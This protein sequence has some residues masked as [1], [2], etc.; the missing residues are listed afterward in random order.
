[1]GNGVSA[2]ATERSSV[3]ELGAGSVSDG[4]SVG[5][6]CSG[7]APLTWLVVAGSTMV[8]GAVAAAR[9]GAPARIGAGAAGALTVVNP[10]KS[11]DA[12]SRAATN[13]TGRGIDP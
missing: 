10:A 8:S 11:V 9:G 12:M 4:T 1:M 13:D 3:S 6:V 2:V 5:E 7:K